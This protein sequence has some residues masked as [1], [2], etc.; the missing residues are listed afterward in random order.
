MKHAAARDHRPI[1]TI[2][3]LLG[4]AACAQAAP[5]DAPSASGTATASG[6]ATGSGIPSASGAPTASATAAGP[7]GTEEF[8]L[9]FEQLVSR[10]EAVETRI[11]ACMAVAGFEYVAN[12]FATVRQAMTSDKSAP[13][14]SDAAFIRQ[15]GYGI[16][17]Q[18][19][20]PI[21]R[22]GLGEDNRRIREALSEAGRVAY[23]HALLGEDREA[24]FA[25]ALEAEDFSRT[26]G[27]T[28]QAVEQE[29]SP[30]EVRQAYFNPVDAL[31]LEDPRVIDALARF[32]S[33]MR[34]AGYEYGHPDD[35]EADLLERLDSVTGGADPSTL[36]GAE[37]N[38]LTALQDYERAVVPVA[39]ECETTLLEPVIDTVEFELLGR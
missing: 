8:G 29:F 25:Y 1:W 19:D 32:A 11:G 21:V 35:V 37:L 2:C 28:R 20:K 36:S 9:T 26:G 17:T 10:V 4:L 15:Y 6:A 14:L 33:C 39:V 5:S 22:L 7:L 18:L 34:G 16:T 13:G 38:A 23:D 30:E 31:V 27:C 24:V 12:D 3:L